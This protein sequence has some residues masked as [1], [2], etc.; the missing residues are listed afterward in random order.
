MREC[1]LIMKGGVTSGVVHPGAVQE[2]A[3]AYRLRSIGGASA[4]AIA[5]VAAAAAEYR[6]QS[7]PSRADPKGFEIMGALSDELAEDVASLF[8]PAPAFAPLFRV[9]KSMT[10][11]AKGRSLRVI[12]RIAQVYRGRVFG[13]LGLGGAL[14]L[15]CLRVGAPWPAALAL[16]AGLVAAVALP[17]FA[18]RKALVVDLPKHD[19]GMC[20]GTTQA[21]YGAKAL[22]DWL[23]DHID[24]IAGNLGPDGTPGAPLT[25]GALEGDDTRPDLGIRIAAMTTD[26]SSQRPY[27]LPLRNALHYF[28]RAEFAALF[29]ARVVDYLCAER[30]PMSSG[31]PGGPEDLYPLPVGPDFPV[32]LCARMSLSFPLLISAV[33]LWRRDEGLPMG[34]GGA[35][36]FRRCL[37]S[38]GGIS[39]NFPILLFDALMPRRPTFGITLTDYEEERHGGVFVSLPERSPTNMAL[40]VRRIGGLTG[41]VMSM[42]NTAKDWQ[43]GLQALM[44]GFA[45]RI[46]EIRLDRETEGGLNLDMPSEVTRRLQARGREA[47]RKLVEG[48]CFDENRWRRALSVLPSIEAAL[49]PL[50]E[51]YTTAPV[52]S[53]LTYA[54]VLTEH[55]PKSYENAEAWRREVL[56]P[57]A[58]R[59]AEMGD[60]AGTRLQ[61]GHLPAQDAS[62][63][64]LATADRQPAR[65]GKGAS[66]V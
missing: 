57:F 3:K 18:L 59:L 8:Q 29:P 16:V 37:F 60:T 26:L 13:A 6:R 51:A 24:T 52:G 44:P 20:P 9:F 55:A 30:A 5:A 48:F 64:L 25:V 12:R 34:P 38:D 58:A 22:T 53:T 40:P 46:V 62:I 28:S 63:R 35:A 36:P 33:P 43:D 11:P 41:F 17:L 10:G 49:E 21:G 23:A 7:S 32:L 1:D 45:E 65:P 56:D 2:L 14:A 39:S 54:Q 42:F 4:G 15:V 27:Q 31:V 61:D 19:F 50:H 66:G 47:G